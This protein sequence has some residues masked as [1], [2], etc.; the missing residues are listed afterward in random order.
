MSEP[1]KIITENDR[2]LITS[3]FYTGWGTYFFKV[4]GEL[5]QNAFVQMSADYDHISQA[6]ALHPSAESAFAVW[7]FAE[8]VEL[9]YTFFE[10][11]AVGGM[12]Q[13]INHRHIMVILPEDE[14]LAAQIVTLCLK[15][16]ATVAPGALY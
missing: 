12:L 8:V 16:K 11:L 3:H 10:L 7:E 13:A 4:K 6:L 14:K 2:A 9:S 15:I 1:V 5:N